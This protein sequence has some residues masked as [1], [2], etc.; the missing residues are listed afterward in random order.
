LCF[1]P[2]PKEIVDAVVGIVH[3][4][5]ARCDLVQLFVGEVVAINSKV[6]FYQQCVSGGL[7]IAS[8]GRCRVP[9]EGLCVEVMEVIPDEAKEQSRDVPSLPAKAGFSSMFVIL[10]SHLVNFWYGPY[11]IRR[12]MVAKINCITAFWVFP[13]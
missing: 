8:R 5:G 10:P 12:A 11:P 7:Y 3:V 1:E 9:F 6:A 4:V 2:E 13:M